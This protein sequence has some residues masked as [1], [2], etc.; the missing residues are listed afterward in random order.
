MPGTI[1]S[2]CF[3]HKFA[4]MRF[5]NLYLD[6]KLNDNISKSSIT[7]L[8]CTFNRQM[9]YTAVITKTNIAHRKFTGKYHQM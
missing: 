3:M 8:S 2:H 1:S 4:F 6:F 7:E 5:K 9:M